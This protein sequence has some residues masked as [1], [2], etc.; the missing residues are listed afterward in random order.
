MRPEG[1]Y[2]AMQAYAGS[3]AYAA[4][5]FSARRRP[6][7]VFFLSCKGCHGMVHAASGTDCDLRSMMHLCFE[8]R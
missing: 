2:A 5:A 7:A 1:N 4:F 3:A 6:S 8:S